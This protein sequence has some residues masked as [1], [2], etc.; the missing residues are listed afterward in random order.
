VRIFLS[1]RR[2]D[3][4]GH[5]GRLYDALAARFGDENVFIDVDTIDPGVDFAE[6][7]TRAVAGCDALIALIGREWLIATDEEGRRRL[8]DP[9][10][11]VRLEL[12]AALEREVV[13][14][15]AYVQE[16]EPPRADR[17]PASLA[18][19]AR[20]QGAELRDVGWRDDVRRLISRLEEPG[21]ARR[22]PPAWKPSRKII[23]VAA[24]VGATALA[25][26]AILVFTPGWSPEPREETVQTGQLSAEENRLLTL[27]PAGTR[28]SCTQ[29]ERE[30]AAQASVSCSGTRLSVEYHLFPR[31]ADLNAWYVQRRETERIEP[32]KGSCTAQSFRG[33]IR[34]RADGRESGKL[35]CFVDSEDESELFWTDTRV[36]VGAEASVYEGTGRPAVTSLLRQWRCCLG[37]ETAN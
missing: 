36:N 3:A 18:P 27:I 26:A 12:E 20:R 8:D 11:F 17:L 4:S 25:A 16:A 5:A 10:D 6:A 2:E 37:L 24:A 35:A 7:I 13:V 33:E 1:Y 9:Q 34:W 32:A 22:E 14:I 21:T 30:P 15:P 29:T 23:A 28:A 31:F 19:L